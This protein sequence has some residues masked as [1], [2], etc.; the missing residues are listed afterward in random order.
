MDEV[1][2]EM[3]DGRGRGEGGGCGRVEEEGK[4]GNEGKEEAGEIKKRMGREK[5]RGR[6]FL[7]VFCG[8]I[9]G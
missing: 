8:G 7:C 5:K 2:V 4:R 1:E 9:E 6:A 3:K